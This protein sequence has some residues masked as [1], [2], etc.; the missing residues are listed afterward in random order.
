MSVFTNK[1]GLLGNQFN[2][3]S[4]LKASDGKFYFGGVDGL[5]A[6]D[7]DSSDQDSSLPPVYISKFSIY[8][9]EI[10]VHSPNS[11]LKQC[12]IHTNEIV[13]PYD[14]SN[15]SFDIAMLSYSTAETNQYYYRMLPLDKEWI[16]AASN[17]NISYACLL[18]TSPSPRD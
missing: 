14:Q 5:I 17:K 13:L 9:K 4:A 11:P 1:D 16:R 8:N 7:P 15:I 18:Y 12:I 6:F 2:Y 3:R 10:T